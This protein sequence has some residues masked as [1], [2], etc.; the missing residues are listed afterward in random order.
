M[1]ATSARIYVLARS[2]EPTQG[3]VDTKT[4]GLGAGTT[5][6]PFNDDYKRH[7]YT[8]TVRLPNIAGRRERP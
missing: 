7:V 2:R 6:G 8:T 5:L 1:N 4:Y 3:Y